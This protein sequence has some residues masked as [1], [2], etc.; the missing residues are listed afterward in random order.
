M[1]LSKND[2]AQHGWLCVWRDRMA[3]A[4][5]HSSLESVAS[6]CDATAPAWVTQ[7]YLNKARLAYQARKESLDRRL[8]G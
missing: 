3:G 1:S 7:A 8:K 5:D 4:K 6:E 2:F